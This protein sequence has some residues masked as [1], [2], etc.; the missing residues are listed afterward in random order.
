MARFKPTSDYYRKIVQSRAGQY[1]LQRM[2][3]AW[4][5]VALALT[6]KLESGY[7]ID[8]RSSRGA[9][10]MYQFLPNTVKLFYAKYGPTGSG[11]FRDLLPKWID[12][13]PDV[14][15]QYALMHL[16]ESYQF[17]IRHGWPV[18]EKPT[19]SWGDDGLLWISVRF[20]YH[21]GPSRVPRFP[22]ESQAV[23]KLFNNE[24]EAIY[25]RALGIGA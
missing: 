21:N 15:G 19:S 24:L 20:Y 10:D 2:P 9:M 1:A 11:S 8:A 7:E 13:D 23:V 16:L 18:L 25:K 5:M 17:A 4:A 14:Q 22:A 12:N 6:A 3:K